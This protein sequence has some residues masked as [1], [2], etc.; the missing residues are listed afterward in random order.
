MKTI[1]IFLSLGGVFLSLLASI[2]WAENKTLPWTEKIQAAVSL[3]YDDAVPVHHQKVA[4]LLE[5][6][7]LRGT[8]YLTIKLVNQFA[9]W[10]QVADNQHELGNHALFH[11]CRQVPKESYAWLED[12]YDLSAYSLDRF[13]DELHTANKFLNLLDGG[14]P[15]TYG[16]N[17]T[18]LTVGSGEHETPM[19]PVLEELF[20]AAR[21]TQT[22][23]IITAS[24]LNYTRLGHFSADNKTFPQVKAE[25]EQA[26]REGGWIIYMIHGVGN[27]THPL[28]MDEE[29]HKKLITWLAE[30]KDSIWTAPVVDVANF[31]KSK[32]IG[33]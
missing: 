17:C 7:G 12:H 15:R 27:G 11:P 28:F 6:Y 26:R 8:F 20:T 18:H 22:N 31:L 9:P 29:E 4:P 32:N 3:S 16:N 13:R 21:G 19:D 23:Q 33:K 14:K 10:K 30:E 5:Q 24:N 1:K 25:I 2:T